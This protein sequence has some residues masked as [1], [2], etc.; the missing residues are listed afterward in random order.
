MTAKTIIGLDLGQA[1]DF[2]AIVVLKTQAAPADPLETD[3][4]V[5][6]LERVRHKPYPEI[7]D[8]VTRL[9]QALRTQGPCDLV[10]D[11]TGVGRGIVDLLRPVQPVR[12]NITGGQAVNLS[13]GFWN[14][15]KKDLIAVTVVAF[16]NEKIKIANSL[17]LGPI[18]AQEM[19]NLKAK[20]NTNGHTELKA[21]W[22]EG[23]HDDLA[24][25][26]ACAVWWAGHKPPVI[27]VY[28][29]RQQV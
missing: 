22:R 21:D 26:C 19:M 17:E 10:V 28:R 2:T 5:I 25:A 12:V 3:L 13:D 7:V 8:H 29:S 4:Q 23:E 16:Q 24:L 18:L 11:A 15:P 6:H 14:V 9:V 1:N 27:P 20:I